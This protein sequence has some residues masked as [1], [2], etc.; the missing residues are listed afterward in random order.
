MFALTVTVSRP[1]GLHVTAFPAMELGAGQASWTTEVC[2]N[3]RTQVY[4]GSISH[5]H[6]VCTVRT[7]IYATGASNV[8]LLTMHR[9]GPEAVTML[10]TPSCWKMRIL[11][12]PTELQ[13]QQ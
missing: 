7:R 2:N 5:A 9:N 8:A 4:L 6:R 12:P 13:C 1:Q 11:A 10:C 3:P